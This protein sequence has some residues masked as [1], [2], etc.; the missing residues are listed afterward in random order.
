MRKNRPKRPLPRSLK[1]NPVAKA[2]G[3]GGLF[4]KRI[5]ARSDVYRRRPKHRKAEISEDN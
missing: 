2:L 3:A 4:R 5:V 1:R